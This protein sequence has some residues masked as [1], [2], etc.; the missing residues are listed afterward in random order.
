VFGEDPKHANCGLEGVSQF[1][2]C[3]ERCPHSLAEG[4]GF[5]G[6]AIG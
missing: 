6:G 2:E 1:G 5:R 4:R 3:V